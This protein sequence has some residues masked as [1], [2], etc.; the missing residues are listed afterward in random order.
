MPL[1]KHVKVDVLP[2]AKNEVKKFGLKKL[3][4]KQ[5][6]IFI[7]NPSH[8]SLDFKPLKGREK[9]IFSF[10]INQKYRAR[11]IKAD[12]SLYQIFQVGDFHK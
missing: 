7:D 12:K 6:K 8:P 5:L 4:D 10:R 9:G 11:L 1:N 3:F 2:E